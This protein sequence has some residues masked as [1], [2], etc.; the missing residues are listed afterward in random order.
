MFCAFKGNKYHVKSLSDQLFLL[1]MI[2]G[3][4]LSSFRIIKN[5]SP[6][7]K[8]QEDSM[9]HR[10]VTRVSEMAYDRGRLRIKVSK[11]IECV[12][13]C[14]NL[15]TLCLLEDESTGDLLTPPDTPG[16]WGQVTQGY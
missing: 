14:F 2:H 11:R 4:S 10:L 12:L 6:R 15:A 16:T 7:G 9:F 1:F 13:H 5:K 8:L 3:R